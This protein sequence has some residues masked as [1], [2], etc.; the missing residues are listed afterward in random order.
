MKRSGG[1]IEDIPEAERIAEQTVN[2]RELS[3]SC[4]HIISVFQENNTGIW[5][6]Q[7]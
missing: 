5:T 4:Y 6:F 2:L 7:E 3:A 1:K